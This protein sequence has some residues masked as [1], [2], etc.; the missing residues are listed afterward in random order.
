MN[1]RDDTTLAW[2]LVGIVWGFLFGLTAAGIFY[3]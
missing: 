3:G 2:L 1:L